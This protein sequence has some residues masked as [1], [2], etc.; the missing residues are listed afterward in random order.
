MSETLSAAASQEP[1]S[2]S[3][4]SQELQ[5]KIEEAFGEGACG[6]GHWPRDGDGR[7]A[8]KRT[9]VA[10]AREWLSGSLLTICVWTLEKLLTM[11]R[12]SDERGWVCVGSMVVV[13]GQ[14][15]A[16]WFEL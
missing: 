7:I 5:Y 2:L 1:D 13:L 11:Q 8:L 10:E 14:L 12:G 15:L 4:A 6:E 9:K 3:I 16:F